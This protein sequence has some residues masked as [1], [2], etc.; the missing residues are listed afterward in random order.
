MFYLFKELSRHRWRTI[1]GISGYL[2]ATL[3]IM[4]ILSV[5]TTN[6]ND[7]VGILKGT[8]THFI[9]YIPA[10]SSCCP[11]AE[12]YSMDGSL[13]AEGGYTMMLNSDLI[14]SL[15][16]IAGIKDAAPYLLYKIFDKDYKSDITLGGIDT[17]SYATMTNVCAPSNL[18]SGRYLS[19]KPGEVVAE[20]SFAQAHKINVG[21]TLNTYGVTLFVGGII[22]SG[23]RPGKADLYAPIDQVRSILK[24]SLSCI[25]DGF[26]MNIIL[27]EVEDARIQSRV[28][29][30]IKS[31]MNFLSV[32]SY[33]CYQPASEVMKIMEGTS[34][35]LS[36][37]V[38]LFL[39]IFSVKTQLTNLLERYSEIGILK[40]LG[41]SDTRLSIQ[42]V[43]GSVI[44]AFTGSIF[45]VLLGI[46]GI[47][48]INSRGIKLFG[49][50]D[51]Q[52]QTEMIPVLILLSVG[53]GL[54]ASLLPVIRL[55]RMR[56]GEMINSFN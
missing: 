42:V 19:G 56:A 22:N 28:I 2:L 6:E 10:G 30:Q 34:T 52:L 11:P 8:G 12:K 23:I 38:F 21:D 41:W 29:S 53:G 13:V 54:I 35:L 33:N 40:S 36:V 24:D 55:H 17:T 18:I 45:G 15:K 46:S 44:Q 1:A 48:L 7:S 31:K 37:V 26:D 43:T 51:L 47:S 5:T 4:L 14:Y 16:E 50:L 49:S 39:I 3:F 32:S 27:V 25:S 20:E 9:V